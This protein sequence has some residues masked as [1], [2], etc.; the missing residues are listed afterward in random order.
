MDARGDR[1][2]LRLQLY[3]NGF[4]PL[5]NKSKM[6]LMKGWSTVTIDRPLIESWEGRKAPERRFMDTGLRC[7][8]IVALDWDIDDAELLN[9][10]LDEIVDKGLVKESLFVR[11]GKPPRELW[12]YRTSEKIGKRTTGHFAP[13]GT[14]DAGG[15]AVEVLGRGCQFAGYGQRSD[16]HEY[17]WPEESL[18]DHVYMDL[19]E[20]TLAEA[21]AVKDYAAAFFERRGLERRSPG[22]GTDE[23]YTHVYDLT[24]DT[25]FEVKD[26]GTLTVE[27]IADILRVNPD[28]VLRAKADTFRPTSGSWACMIS[29]AGGVVCVSDHGTY[30]THFPEGEDARGSMAKLGQMLLERAK[31]RASALPD[32]ELA[33]LPFDT[34]KPLDVNLRIA[35]DRYAYVER[36]NLAVDITD[37]SVRMTAEHF[38]NLMA[39]FYEEDPGAKG[40]KKIA[41][42]ADLWLQ[43][44]ARRDVRTIAMRPDR[45]YP[46]YR[47][48]G[49]SHLNTYR[50]LVLP[51]NGDPEVGM[52]F[53]RRLLPVESERTYFTRWLSYKLQHPDTRGPGII[54]VAHDSYGTGRGT[55]FEILFR[56]F[57]DGLVRKIDFST[58]AGK[59]YQSQYNEWLADS[60]MVLVDEA[61]ESSTTLS[62]WQMRNNAYEKL[63][64][65]VDPGVSRVNIIRKGLKNTSGISYASMIIATNHMDSVVLPTGD[66]RFFICENGAPQSAEYWEDVYRWIRTD[67]NI[68]AFVE[69][70]K[71]VD[72]ADYTPFSLPPMTA[73]KADMIDA[74]TS[75]LDRLME[76]VLREMPNTLLCKEQ[77]ILR[78]EDRVA[79][80]SA[81]LPD[82]WTRI[83]ERMF[84]RATRKL[85]G[86]TDR[87]KIE[88]KIR[89]VRVHGSRYSQD[90]VASQQSVIDEVLRNGP[91]VRQ[92]KTGAQVIRF[93][94]RKD[95]QRIS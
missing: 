1:T 81:D 74:G 6:C 49:A 52:E 73:A 47:E 86:G 85:P 25:E 54:M 83:A 65:V 82:D 28:E 36:D 72:L 22:G 62:R 33:H 4:T 55:L 8:D 76:E 79:E 39:K 71:K 70:L 90:I 59:T 77:V 61:Q 31:K 16:E 43:H 41:R 69:A 56:M 26:F 80:S 13:P 75:E 42:L 20:I 46:L 14:E 51:S 63:K 67:G 21:E 37:M 66:R 19:P 53:L 48:D 23:G 24:P 5:P 57:A 15:F 18:L 92:I 29:L 78:I 89:T 27:E 88:G 34:S 17:I 68:G 45:P 7:G 2:K 87:V 32:P 3:D 60:L 35:L 91:L 58:L 10:L 93:P 94:E 38:R 12:V 11:V 9:D 40:G 30:T 50:S 44:P 64:E 95:A 84:L